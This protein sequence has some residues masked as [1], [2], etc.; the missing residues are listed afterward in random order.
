MGVF[1]RVLQQ[2]MEAVSVT[3]SLPDQSVSSLLSPVHRHGN[4]GERERKM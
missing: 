3:S 1:F 4:L 2:E